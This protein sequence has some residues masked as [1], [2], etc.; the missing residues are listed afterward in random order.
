MALFHSF[1]AEFNCK[2]F[3]ATTESEPNQ[4]SRE[5]TDGAEESL[6][7]LQTPMPR[8][9]ITSVDFYQVLPCRTENI[10]LN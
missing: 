3:R 1:D 6:H 10:T 9:F 8:A 4:S 2:Y 7:S 5:R